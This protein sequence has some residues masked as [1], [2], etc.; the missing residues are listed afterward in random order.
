MMKVVHERMEKDGFLTIAEVAKETDIPAETVRRYVRRH[1]HHLKMKKNGKAY[2]ISRAS[3]EVIEKIRAL[4]DAG[5]DAEAVDDALSAAGITVTVDVDESGN[6]SAVDVGKVLQ[7][8]AS[9]MKELKHG[10]EQQVKFNQALMQKLDDQQA[11]IDNSLK[12]R[13]ARLMEALRHGQEA[14]A[15]SAD[16]QKKDDE[17]QGGNWFSK[18]FKK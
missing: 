16:T 13:D 6:H 10:Y 14:A 8:M 15:L 4:Y 3:I 9:D 1:G 18:L 17:K 2:N 7:D 5:K 11:Y 12:E